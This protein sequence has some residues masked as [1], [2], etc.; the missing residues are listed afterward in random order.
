VIMPEVLEIE[1][2]GEASVTLSLR[3]D[4]DLYQPD[5]LY[6]GELQLVRGREPRIDVPLRI[7]A[8]RRTRQ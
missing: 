4:E 3:L 1:P 2:G 5:A 6:V 7:T 8:T